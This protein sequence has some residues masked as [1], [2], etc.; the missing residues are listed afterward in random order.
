MEFDVT[1]NNLKNIKRREIEGVLAKSERVRDNKQQF[2]LQLKTYR[3][4]VRE[5]SYLALPK[6]KTQRDPKISEQSQIKFFCSNILITNHE[7]KIIRERISDN[8]E[9]R[10][11]RKEST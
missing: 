6:R 3:K 1:I 7:Q 9:Q 2:V 10:R 5:I 8:T 4:I 11:I